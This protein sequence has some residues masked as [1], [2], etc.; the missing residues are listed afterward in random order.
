MTLL[1]TV[2]A[3]HTHRDITFCS[4]PFHNGQFNEDI[5]PNHKMYTVEMKSIKN[6]TLND[7][8]TLE[9]HISCCEYASLQDTKYVAFWAPQQCHEINHI[10]VLLGSDAR[11]IVLKLELVNWSLDLVQ[12]LQRQIKNCVETT[13]TFQDTMTMGKRLLNHLVYTSRKFKEQR[14][15]ID[16]ISFCVRP[17]RRLIQCQRRGSPFEQEFTSALLKDYPAFVFDRKIAELIG[18]RSP[19]TLTIT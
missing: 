14:I 18:S 1:T 5:V 12:A 9:F 6:M 13:A 11:R 10:N 15:K 19:S 8:S 3:V 2:D 4:G 16:Q 7:L 17:I